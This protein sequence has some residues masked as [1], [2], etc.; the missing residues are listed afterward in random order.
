MRA[1]LIFLVV[2][3]VT[4][5]FSIPGFSKDPD[6]SWGYRFD[7]EIAQVL[8]TANELTIYSLN[9]DHP[10]KPKTDLF[11]TYPILGKAY[12]KGKQAYE[13]T[14]AFKAAVDHGGRQA[15]CFNPRHALSIVANGHTY[16]YLL[17]YECGSGMVIKDGWIFM[18]SFEAGGSPDVLNHLLSEAKIP[19][20]KTGK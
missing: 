12:L 19:L 14:A 15:L 4:T 9:M 7:G 20:S 13:A 8:E 10:T 16:D 18:G 17:C 2:L 5:G 1:A 11:Y 6:F 3:I